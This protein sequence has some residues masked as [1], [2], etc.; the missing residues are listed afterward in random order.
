MGIFKNYYNN[1]YETKINEK[2]EEICSLIPE[3]EFSNWWYKSAVNCVIEQN[4]S[5]EEELLNEFMG[6]I[7]NFFGGNK[8]QTPL[9]PQ[10][11]RHTEPPA[12]TPT[13]P[14]VPA[15]SD[16]IQTKIKASTSVVKNALAKAMYD[17]VEKMKTNRDSIGVQVA[18]KISQRLGST[19][20]SFNWK[21]AEG[22]FDK[23]T[24]FGPA[25]NTGVGNN[26][27]NRWASV[28]DNPQNTEKLANVYARK[29]GVQPQEIQNLIQSGY[30][31]P[32]EWEHIL[33]G[34][35]K[36]LAHHHLRNN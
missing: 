26:V 5:N 6:G 16:N 3:N 34:N 23:N 2:I 20:D 36:P 31:N 28:V 18:N 32:Y 11:L 30:K 1:R 7:K 29:L 13:T 24:E 33:T 14:K 35:V 10:H 4:Y 25:N 8:E 21:R 27:V 12:S 19:L 17:V 22:K 9:V 15:L